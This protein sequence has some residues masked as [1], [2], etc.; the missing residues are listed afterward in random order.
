[1]LHVAQSTETNA[2]RPSGSLGASVESELILRPIRRA[3]E[4]HPSLESA[5]DLLGREV[6]HDAGVARRVVLQD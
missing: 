2:T 1:M 6:G 3:I 5:L 4:S